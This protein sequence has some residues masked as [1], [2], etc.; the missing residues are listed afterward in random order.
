MKD[1]VTGM[2]KGGTYALVMV[3][4]EGLCL[5][6]GRLGVHDLSAG[7]YVY[8][9]SALNGL[10]GRISYHLRS[11]KKFHWHI[12]YLLSCAKVAEIWYTVSHERLE[13]VWSTVLQLLP[14]ASH[15][16]R[17]FGAS[18]CRCYSHL[19]YFRTA[20]SLDLFNDKLRQYELSEV[21]R[22]KFAGFC[23]ST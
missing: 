3:L 7:Y 9:G 6:V 22:A 11:E 20:P 13:C 12:D 18:D 15:S 10:S 23:L 1:C 16:I 21:H 5:Q 4:E 8:M 17:G 2:S 14:G 19:G